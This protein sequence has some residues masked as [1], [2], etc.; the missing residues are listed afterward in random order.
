[1]RG[2]VSGVSSGWWANP[3]FAAARAAEFELLVAF[4]FITVLFVCE[5]LTHLYG[6]AST[7][8]TFSTRPLVEP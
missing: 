8:G 4:V 7:E 5:R 2:M 6:L 1:M 3:L